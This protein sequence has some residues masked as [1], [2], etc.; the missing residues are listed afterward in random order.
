MSA[1]RGS[2]CRAAIAADLVLGSWR[3]ARFSAARARLAEPQSE[4]VSR[5]RRGATCNRT[6]SLRVLGSEYERMDEAA[7]RKW[8]ER[9]AAVLERASDLRLRITRAI[10]RVLEHPLQQL[11][12]RARPPI[13][14][15]PR[16]TSRLRPSS[17]ALGANRS[18]SARHARPAR[19]ASYATASHRI[20]SSIR[21]ARRYS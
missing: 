11:D 19:A 12:V 1:A 10:E 9:H 13:G 2:Y 16:S 14:V 21:V 7:L 3:F 18:R 4:R 8:A 20:P 6:R 17:K 5:A 15:T